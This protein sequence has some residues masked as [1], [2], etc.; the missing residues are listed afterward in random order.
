MGKI[1]RVVDYESTES[2]SFQLIYDLLKQ[3]TASYDDFA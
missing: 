2:D 3:L 1:R